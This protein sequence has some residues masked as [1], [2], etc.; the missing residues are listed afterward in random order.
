MKQKIVRRASALVLA[1]CL[2]AGAALPALAASAKEEVIYA[3]LDASGT[4]TGVYAVNSFAVQAGDTVTDHGSYTAVRNMTT[5][6]PL[7]HSGDTVTAT[8]AE[9]GKLYYEGTMDTATALPWLVK[10]TYTLDGAE[11]APEEL[12]GKSGALTIRLQVSRNPDCTGDFF[13]QYALQVTMTLD[14]DRAQNIVADGATMA[15][16]GSNKQLS[17]ILLP[18]SDSDVTVT[19]DVT[20]FAMN[21][22]SLNG[23][24][25]RLNLDLDGADLTGMLDRL[26]SGSVQ[27]D[28]GANA[29]ADGIAQVQA[30]LDTLNGKSGELTG[31]SAKVKAALTQMQTALNGVSASTDQ[32]TTLLDASTQIQ[33]G[34]AQLDAGAAQ[35]DEQVSYD[36]YKA[37]LKENGLD[38]DQLKDG[39]AKAME[40]LEQLARVMP[41]LKDVI[42]L[43]KGSSANIDAMETYLNTVHDGVAQL[44]VRC[45][46]ASAGQCPDRDAG[47]PFGADRRR[48]PAGQPVRPTGQRSERLHRR[49]G[50]AESRSAAADRRCR[51]ADRR[52][53]RAAQQC[54]RDRHGRPAG[55]PAGRPERQQRGGELY[56]CREH[57]CFRRAVRPADGGHRGPGPGGRAGGRPRGADF[58]A[59]TAEAVRAV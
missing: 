33:N 53:R 25:L 11:I 8:V 35:L 2:L 6:D 47:Q 1:G 23:V 58:L 34:I 36:A 7:E 56:F 26:Q 54:F 37:I 10:L 29:L 49:C 59:E 51:P 12:G 13:D 19:A 30:G 24:K 27:L 42:L 55:Q 14:T 15:N 44:H 16:V 9:D 31:G 48:E 41:Q 3:N 20:D 21:A 17:Y 52:H 22:I 18:G 57:R 46:G 40:Q 50:P 5:T 4:V 45:R 32:L 28:D 43:L 39:N 38:L